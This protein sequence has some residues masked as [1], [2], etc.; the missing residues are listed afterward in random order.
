MVPSQAEQFVVQYMFLLICDHFG[1]HQ[2][3][4]YLVLM[5]VQTLPCYS[6]T[7]DQYI[8]YQMFCDV[9]SVQEFSLM[10]SRFLVLLTDSFMGRGTE[11]VKPSLPELP[12]AVPN[13]HDPLRKDLPEH[14]RV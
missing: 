10:A 7:R 14:L 8:V 5:C 6:V 4:L 13:D 1:R 9:L 3:T 11:L 12:Q 2:D